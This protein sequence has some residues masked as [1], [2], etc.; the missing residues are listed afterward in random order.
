VI[1]PVATIFGS[2]SAYLSMADICHPSGYKLAMLNHKLINLATEL[3]T[4]EMEDTGLFKQL[5]SGE[6]FTTRNIY[7]RPFEMK[8]TATLVF[9]ANSL[10]RFKYG[11]AA[12][13]RRLRFSNQVTNPDVKL[14]ERVAMDAPGLLVELVYRAQALLAGR[15]LYEPGQFGQETL[16]R[17]AVSNDPVGSFVSRV[18]ALG[19]DYQC[20]KTLIGDAFTDFRV[21]Y[22]ISDKLDD[23]LFFRQLYER[24]PSV[25]SKRIRDDD[26]S[27]IYVLSGITLQEIKNI[28]PVQPPS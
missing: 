21:Q 4:L 9:L 13:A 14:K 28:H 6:S 2:S 10:P 19:P 8:S 12:E 20:A 11:T 7:G 25:R 23:S 24:F 3:N 16:Q 22:G 5:V 27:R 26:D 15:P 1:A 18:C 17:F